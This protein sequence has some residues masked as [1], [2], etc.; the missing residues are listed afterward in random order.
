MNIGED[1]KLTGKNIG[2]AI[3][4]TGIYLHP[5]F[6]NRVTAFQDFIYGRKKP[7]DDNSHGTH[8]AGRI[9]GSGR[10]SGGRYKGIA[11]GC[12]VAALKVLD[13]IGNGKKEDVLKA[14]AWILANRRKYNLRIVNISVGTTYKTRSEQDVL[15]QSVE[16]LWDEG[17]VVVAAAGNQ[18]PREGSITAPG[19]CKKIITVGSSDMLRGDRGIS[20]RGPTFECVCKPDIVVPGNHIISCNAP[21]PG[22]ME[23]YVRKSGTSMSTPV[24]AGAAALLLEGK[25]DLTN[26]EVKMILRESTDD[27][28]LPHNQQGWGRFN[29]AKMKKA[30][31][32]PENC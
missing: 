24:I 4:D 5:D 1:M 27:L 12:T 6:D 28:G 17:L 11:P 31:G 13:R 15:I 26:V 3:V 20:S 7:Y 16:K 30:A 2:V 22:S 14:V 25:P 19:C 18:G 8:V 29:L 10:L 21:H 23:W 32:F 9:M